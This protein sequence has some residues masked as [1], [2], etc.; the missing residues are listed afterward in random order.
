MLRL[1]QKPRPRAGALLLLALALTLSGC[2]GIYLDPGPRPATLAVSAAAAV[3]PQQV[4]ETLEAKVRLSPLAFVTRGEI[5]PPLWDLRAFVPRPDGGLTP[6]RPV[7]PVAN[8]E[9]HQFAA[10]AE[11]LAPAGVYDVVFL[12]ECSVRYL[13]YDAYYPTEEYAYIVTWKAQSKLT[14]PEGGRLAVEPFRGHR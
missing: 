9:G 1:A 12:L 7:K 5:S 6:L 13:S 4:R 3:T 10:T 8:Q 2:A 14:M 11:F